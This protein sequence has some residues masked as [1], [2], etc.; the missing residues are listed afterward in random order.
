MILTIEQVKDIKKAFMQEYV[1]PVQ[2]REYV[3][4]CGI[5]KVGIFNA[6]ASDEEKN[7]FCLKVGLL[8]PLPPDMSIPSEY[9][10]INVFVEVTGE[11]RPL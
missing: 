11:I 1:F 10:G 9:Q 3:N 8:K 2:W 5:S 4:M 7:N 6:D